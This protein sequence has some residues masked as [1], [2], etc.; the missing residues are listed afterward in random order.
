MIAKLHNPDR[1]RCTA[2]TVARRQLAQS[3]TRKRNWKAFA[4]TG[5]VARGDACIH[6]D[7]DCWAIG[8]D[9]EVIRFVK[10]GVSCTV[11]VES[12]SRVYSDAHLDHVDVEAAM[13]LWDPD[14]IFDKLKVQ[15]RNRRAERIAKTLAQT[16]RL[17]Q[18][19]W[20]HTKDNDPLVARW[21]SYEVGLRLIGLHYF[22]LFDQKHFKFR[23]LVENLGEPQLGLAK[24]LLWLP[25]QIDI[26]KLSALYER[27]FEICS[28]TNF[29]EIHKPIEHI[30][31][32]RKGSI[33]P[34]L[35]GLRRHY[36]KNFISRFQN[37]NTIAGISKL[38][39]VT[40]SVFRH[41]TK[42]LL[43]IPLQHTVKTN[44]NMCDLVNN[45]IALTAPEIRDQL[46]DVFKASN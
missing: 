44:K 38:L 41:Y 20:N 10:D 31:K 32:I 27:F 11:F 39:G 37:E 35:L 40:P 2:A 25:P 29:K 28:F 4:I 30:S 18:A 26:E 14:T 9:E 24:R 36:S 33:E 23:H 5:S 43:H 12:I 21:N 7:L 16:R 3:L 34:G 42:A 45:Y 19:Y 46:N 13:P 17:V 15:R 22:L 6:S 1:V 8:P